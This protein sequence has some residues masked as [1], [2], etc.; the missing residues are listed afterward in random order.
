MTKVIALRPIRPEDR[1]LLCRIYGSTR[2]EELAP[3]PWT[4]EQKAAFVRQQFDAQTSY[5][6]EQYPE[7]ERFVVEVDGTPA[8][9]LYVQRWPK[10]IRLVDIALLPDFRGRGVGTELIQGLFSEAARDGK[11]VTIHVEIFNP[12]RVLYERLGFAPKGEQGM[13]VL[14]EWKPEAVG[15][16][17]S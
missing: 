14:M 12:A 8:G 5:W 4:D 7:A 2:T 16:G 11:P 1:D 10:E 9:R 17:V 13:Y 15:A 6:D 3:V